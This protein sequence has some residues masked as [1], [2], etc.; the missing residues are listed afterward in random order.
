[1]I[2]GNYTATYTLLIINSLVNTNLNLLDRHT[3]DCCNVFYS[4]YSQ[5]TVLNGPFPAG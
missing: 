4:L 1:M 3:F 2:T 5:S